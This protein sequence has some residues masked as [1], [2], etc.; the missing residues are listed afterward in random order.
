[1]KQRIEKLEKEIA[2]L[3]AQ[4][5]QGFEQGQYWEADNGSVVQVVNVKGNR[6]RLSDISTDK[7]IDYRWPVSLLMEGRLLSE[8]EIKEALVAEAKRRGYTPHNFRCIIDQRDEPLEWCG[9]QYCQDDGLLLGNKCVYLQGEWAEIIEKDTV[10][11]NGVECEV[12]GDRIQF[13]CGDG[14]EMEHFRI[15]KAL[16]GVYDLTVTREGEDI[17]PQ[18]KKLGEQI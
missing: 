2:E 4:L 13:G 6:C 12:K 8:E 5:D 11:I 17:T 14:V 15:F 7:D 10:T 18:I 9:Y 16:V 3:K 1:M